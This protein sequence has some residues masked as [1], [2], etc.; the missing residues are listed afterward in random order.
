MACV[1]RA[2]PMMGPVRDW[3]S[4]SMMRPCVAAFDRST[5]SGFPFRFLSLP[6]EGALPE[7]LGCALREMACLKAAS[8]VHLRGSRRSV[9][10]S[11]V[12]NDRTMHTNAGEKPRR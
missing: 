3:G 5:M 7:S 11:K 1:R 9:L 4:G 12:R 2:R 6:C 8:S 10:V